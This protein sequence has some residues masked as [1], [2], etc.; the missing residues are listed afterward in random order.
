MNSVAIRLAAL[1]LFGLGCTA[2]AANLVGSEPC[3]ACHPDLWSKFNRN[4]HFRTYP[5]THGEPVPNTGCEGCH[6]P[7]GDHVKHP[8][9][10]S[11]FAFSTHTP[12]EAAERCLT[13]HAEDLSR[14]N[15]RR[16]EHTRAGVNCLSCHSIHSSAPETR[17]LVSD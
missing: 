13:C 8:S 3:R 16:S 6:G 2:K 1:A 12:Q 15:V 5:A 9:K 14:A 11:I 10:T 17:L 4:A 7:G